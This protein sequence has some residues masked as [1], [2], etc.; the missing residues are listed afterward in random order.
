MEDKN[1]LLIKEVDRLSSKVNTLT[2]YAEKYFALKEFFNRTEANN[3]NADQEILA[4]STE[5][6]ILDPYYPDIKI[7]RYQYDILKKKT[8]YGEAVR[9]LLDIIFEPAEVSNKS[10]SLLKK[11]YPDRINA[12]ERY[13]MAFF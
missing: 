8:K 2:I 13:S 7:R 6:L 1:I 4:K 10:Y 11:E 9:M 3:E 12:I 5:E